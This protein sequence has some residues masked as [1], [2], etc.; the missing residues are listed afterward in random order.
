MFNG[1][2]LAFVKGYKLKDSSQQQE[3]P[4]EEPKQIAAE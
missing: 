1:G 2:R 3:L 4:L